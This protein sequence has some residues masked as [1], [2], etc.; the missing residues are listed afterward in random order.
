MRCSLCIAV[1]SH[2]CVYHLVCLPLLSRSEFWRCF[3]TS[4][5][6]P[7][8][9][10]SPV[11]LSLSLD[12]AW[13]KTFLNVLGGDVFVLWGVFPFVLQQIFLVEV[14]TNFLFYFAFTF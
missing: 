9:W 7:E 8:T 2:M 6:I 13:R 4:M 10:P 12:A 1:L 5:P 3:Q 11:H 14:T